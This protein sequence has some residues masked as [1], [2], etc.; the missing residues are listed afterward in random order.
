[1]W[2]CA[3]QALPAFPPPQNGLLSLV[4]DSPRTGQ[5]GQKHPV[6]QQTRRRHH[7]PS[8]VGFRIVVLMAQWG[9][10]RLPGEF[11][12]RRRPGEPGD[13]PDKARFRQML[14][15]F[16]LPAWGQQVIVVA[17][18]ADASGATLALLQD[19]G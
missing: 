4:V 9:V 17:D 19:L 11:L 7:H 13:P 16:P 15:D 12:L 8:S 5:R 3:D 14:R 2:G 18:A 6:A 1:L 10:D